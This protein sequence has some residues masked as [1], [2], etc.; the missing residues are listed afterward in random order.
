[1]PKK[2]PNRH[3]ATIIAGAFLVVAVWGLSFDSSAANAAGEEDIGDHMNMGIMYHWYQEQVLK[4]EKVIEKVHPIKED[5]SKEPV[6]REEEKTK[7]PTKT[8]PVIVHEEENVVKPTEEKPAMVHEDVKVEKPPEAKSAIKHEEKKAEKPAKKKAGEDLTAEASDPTAPLYQIS[9]TNFYSS[10]LYDAEGSTN[11]FQFQPVLPI[12]QSERIPFAQ[13][14]RFTVP[15][16]T[17]PEPDRTT[18]LGDIVFLDL[19]VPKPKSWGIWGVGLTMVAPT[20]RED[21]L[22]SG[23]WQIGPAATF[24]YFKIKKWQLG[25]I[26][27]NPVSFAGDSSRPDVNT[28]IFQPIINRMIGKWYVG[29]G[30]FTWSVDWTDDAAVTIPLGFQVGRIT[31]IGKYKY[32]LSGEVEYTVVNEAE[33]TVPE[34]GFR[35]GVVLLLPK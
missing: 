2:W 32:N 9:I 23:K 34:W 16:I 3:Y 31:Q 4:T 14:V 6:K 20:A 11:L 13:I 17:T 24:M 19:F 12:S 1:M 27:E 33:G 8:K 7:E 28:F 5:E 26:L 25:C 35:L 22:G 21:S 29:I 10:N 15:V 18:G 30:D